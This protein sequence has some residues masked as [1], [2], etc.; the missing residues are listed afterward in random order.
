MSR[1]TYPPIFL[2][3]NFELNVQNQTRPELALSNILTAVATEDVRR[4]RRKWI[5]QDA[6]VARIPPN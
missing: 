5:P 6:M 1:A 2:L 4:Q 3:T